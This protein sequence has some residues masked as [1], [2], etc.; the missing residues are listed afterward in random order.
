M[1]LFGIIASLFLFVS[2]GFG[3]S[4]HPS[5]ETLPSK[6]EEIFNPNNS[7]P[8]FL[9][10]YLPTCGH[11]MAYNETFLNPSLKTFLHENVKAYQLDLSKKEN[12]DFLRKRKIYVYSTP[13]FLVF[14]PKG[15]LWNFDAATEDKNSVE[16]IKFLINK[17]ISSTS[18]Q[19]I[20]FNKFKTTTLN[21]DELFEVGMFTR[22]SLDTSN[23]IK[24][25]N[26]LVKSIPASAYETEKSFKIIQQLM[27]DEENPLYEYF[28]QHLKSYEKFEDSVFVRKVA[29]N[30]VMNSVYN[31]DAKN[32]SRARFEKMKTYLIK[33]GIPARSVATRFI[34]YEV[35][36]SLREGKPQEAVAQITKYYEGKPIPPREKEFWCNTLKSYNSNLKNCPL[37]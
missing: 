5:F 33:I 2:V 9:E 35:S 8:I 1:K 4:A 24:A 26:E 31:P 11:C 25:I 14:G 12:M 30:V 34:Y 32:Y 18:R 23:N 21:P 15:D 36:K 17:A 27:M 19:S 16:G 6:L 37:Q 20:L 10:A 7:K 22:Y 28:I 29:E 3:Q 13:T